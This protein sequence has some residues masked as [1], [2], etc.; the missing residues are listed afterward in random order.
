MKSDAEREL[1]LQDKERQE[2]QDIDDAIAAESADTGNDKA[3]SDNDDTNDDDDTAVDD[4]GDSKEDNDNDDEEDD[5][6]GDSMDTEDSIGKDSDMDKDIDDD[7]PTQSRLSKILS[8]LSSAS[9]SKQ[10]SISVSGKGIPDS[11]KDS[12]DETTVGAMD[13]ADRDYLFNTDDP[14]IKAPTAEDMEFLAGVDSDEGVS[15]AE[16]EKL[17]KAELEG[18][19]RA[20]KDDASADEYLYGT[21]T[22]GTAGGGRM[23]RKTT[24]YTAS[25]NR[26]R[27]RRDTGS[28]DASLS[29]IGRDLGI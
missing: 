19:R 16:Q 29:G 15:L 14:R 1:E 17:D 3:I 8:K 25:L 13:D 4:N 10:P 27:K 12:E 21:K 7:E 24:K 20:E 18:I 23:Q 28:G 9:V 2:D 11:D 22:D 6:N 5:T 26:A